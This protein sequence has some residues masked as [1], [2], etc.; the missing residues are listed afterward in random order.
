MRLLAGIFL[1]TGCASAPAPQQPVS[2]PA[3]PVQQTILL[4]VWQTEV[5]EDVAIFRAIR[6]SL[7][8]PA[9]ALDLYDSATQGLASISGEPTA[10]AIDTFKGYVEKPDQNRQ[11]MDKLREDKLA[12]DKKTDALEAK[13]EAER[14]ARINAETEANQARESERLAKIEARKSEAVGVLTKIGAGAVAMG[15]VALMFGHFMGISK[16]TAGVV[17]GAGLGVAV[18]APWLIDLAEMKWIIIG[19][20]AFLG[21][22]LVVFAAIKTWRSLR[23]KS[24]EAPPSP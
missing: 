10:K 11:I 18:A 7:S 16:L 5:A 20:L 15:V 24:N 12:L 13:V 1:L 22:D 2:P 23:P 21:M 14:V 6:P 9:S 4:D 3:E 19:L 8:G 17:I